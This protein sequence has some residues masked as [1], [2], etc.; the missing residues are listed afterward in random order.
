MVVF[1]LIRWHSA[2]LVLNLAQNCVCVETC[3]VALVGGLFKDNVAVNRFHFSFYI[4]F[5]TLCVP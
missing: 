4:L 3:S 1:M 5:C 2:I